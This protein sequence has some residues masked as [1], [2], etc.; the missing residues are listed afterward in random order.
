MKKLLYFILL[1]LFTT[2]SIAYEQT[3]TSISCYGDYQV[4]VK[5]YENITYDVRN[6][7]V[8]KETLNRF[9]NCSCSNSQVIIYQPEN[10]IGK[11]DVVVEYYLTNI[12][13]EDKRTNYFDSVMINSNPPVVESKP[14]NV[15]LI[16]FI[17]IILFVLGIFGTAIWY[18]Y[19]WLF[20]EDNENTLHKKTIDLTKRTQ[21]LVEDEK[22]KE[23]V[24]DEAFKILKKL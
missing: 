12:T 6:C 18:G 1:V 9:W 13:N 2:S 5:Q 10:L 20:K 22:M 15:N 16:I 17:L 19:K 23:D 11:Y 14:I 7:Y 24:S 3:I 8:Y 4:R 21:T